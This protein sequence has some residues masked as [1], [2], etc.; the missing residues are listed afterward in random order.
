MNLRLLKQKP[1]Q[2]SPPE[3]T[4]SGP[5]NGEVLHHDKYLRG[6]N[7]FAVMTNE[8]FRSYYL[9]PYLDPSLFVE[10]RSLLENFQKS[11]W[12]VKSVYAIDPF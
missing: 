7:R 3:N 6:I 11:N 9:N 8:E 1:P 4:L 5:A 12:A 10:T 2:G